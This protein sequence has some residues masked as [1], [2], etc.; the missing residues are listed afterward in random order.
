LNNRNAPWPAPPSPAIAPAK[1]L[2]LLAVFWT[3][4]MQPAFAH[5][6][7]E[8]GQTLNF[9]LAFLSGLA[10]PVINLEHLAYV[11][12]I[13]VLVAVG[14]GS[15]YL[16]ALFVGG[17]TVGCLLAANGFVVPYGE[18]LVLVALTIIGLALILGRSRIG[19]VDAAGFIVT[20][21]I[22]GSVYA[23]DILGEVHTAVVGYLLGFAVIQSVVA[24]SA[25]MMAF[26]LWRGDRL[27]ENA[28]I[29]GG[30]VAGVG[31]TVMFQ[32]VVRSLPMVS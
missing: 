2:V 31:L 28:R 14:Q 11:I 19:I 4:T 10:H 20:G 1:L 3:A 26:W 9:E 6:A 12:A 24:T 8:A 15:R 16:P 13:G 7:L 17:T 22:H 27:Y 32:M 18:V 5:H 23:Q 29:V 21:I 30:L 25:M